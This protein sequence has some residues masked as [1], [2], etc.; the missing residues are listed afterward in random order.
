MKQTSQKSLLFRQNVNRIIARVLLVV[1]RRIRKPGECASSPVREKVSHVERQVH[2]S[3]LDCNVL[4]VK[5][6][7][8][9][10]EFRVF[11]APFDFRSRFLVRYAVFSLGWCAFERKRGGRMA[12][13]SMT[14]NFRIEDAAI[15]S[16][17]YTNSPQNTAML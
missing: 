5:H 6:E 12:T 14:A 4:F 1:V 2:D 3:V 10:E 15:Q 17:R 8:R 9:V 13:S 7:G 11:R 16:E